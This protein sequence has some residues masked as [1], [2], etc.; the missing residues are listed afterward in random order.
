MGYRHHIGILEKN[1]HELIKKMSVKQLKKWYGDEYVPCYKI[2]KE[3][4]ELGKYYDDNFMKPFKK[5]VFTKKATQKLYE[6]DQDFYIISK[7]G[8]EAIIDDY[9]Q[10]VLE[11]YT[12]LLKQ[13]KTDLL[14]NR[15]TTIEQAI[16][17]KI[18]TWGENC[19]KFK[20]YPYSIQ[21]EQITTSWDF[22]Y[23]IF[24]LVR[25]Y[26]TIDWENQLITIT[27]W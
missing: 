13:D 27:A 24:E 3:V 23:A 19:T 22:E 8:F 21:G 17:S 15:I 9:R 10:R 14:I 12:L 7:E 25:I 18:R 26:K 5:K 4:Y 16:E 11:Y 6:G 20:L 1:K 2:T